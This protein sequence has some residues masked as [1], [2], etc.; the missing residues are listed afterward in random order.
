MTVLLATIVFGFGVSKITTN[1]DVADVLPRGDPNT[2]AAHNLTERFRSTFTQQVTLQLHVDEVGN[3]WAKDNAKLEYRYLQMVTGPASQGGLPVNQFPTNIRPDQLNITD[4]VYVRAMEELVRFIQDGTDF[5]RTIS[6]SN[7]YALINWTIAGG[8]GAP[9][10]SSFALPGYKTP[11]D[12]QRYA[13]VDQGVKAAVLN[14]VDAIASPSWNHAAALFMPAADNKLPTPELGKQIL[15][16][17]DLYIKAVCEGK[18]EFTVF[19]DCDEGPNAGIHNR[20]LFTVDLPIA[21]AHSSALVQEDTVRLMP[22]VG[23]FILVCLY[24]AFRNFR[25]IAVCFTTLAVGVVWSYGTMGYMNIALNTLNMTIVPLVMGVGIDYSIHMINEFVEHKSQGHSDAEAFR[26][27]G[28]RSGLALL[29]ASATTVGGLT[30][31][32]FSPSV[33][34]AQLGVISAVALTTIYLLAITFIPAALT[35]LGGSEKMG[36]Q[37]NRSKLMPALARGVSRARYLVLVV[38]IVVSGMAYLGVQNLHKEAFGDPGKNYLPSDPVRQEHEKGLAYFYEASNSD[39]KAN[40][41]TFQGPGV[42]TPEAM[43]YYRAIETNLKTKSHVIPDTLRTV[44]FF[45][46]TWLKVKGGAPGAGGSLALEQLLGRGVL[47]GPVAGAANPFPSTEEEIRDEV[48]QM[49]N[50]PMRELAAIIVNYPVVNQDKELGMTAM[51]FSVRAL[52]Y[53]EAEEVWFEVFD[54]VEDANRLFGGQPPAGISVAFVG[55]TATNYLFIAKELPWLTY[56]NITSNIILGILVFSLTRSVKITFVTLLISSLTTLWWFAVLP[57]F[58]IGL[59]ITLTLPIAFIVAIGTDYAVHFMWNIRQT[60]NAREVF[61]S[62]GKAV[63]FSFLTS[64]GAFIFFIFLQNVAVSRTMIATT[65]AFSV[66]F[67]VTMLAVPTFFKVHERGW[68]P[69]VSEDEL[70]AEPLVAPKRLK[71]ES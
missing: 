40:I 67:V 3:A 20:P 35:L 57:L 10:E 59:A 39:E 54:A 29:I 22:M 38:L 58:G 34:I 1:V 69:P 37:F 17:R 41:L 45:I 66:I 18:T 47:P 24:I 49:F 32:I 64:T 25:A 4:E 52:T 71:T 42:L 2:E 33:L 28:S 43:D 30:V 21:N 61:E 7:I 19:A 56:M 11:A 6:I 60:G 31:L 65:I 14:T 63:L 13:L 27:A 12:S 5:D 70:P 9:D 53:E 68:H 36:A 55:N 8:Q 50:S 15:A 23:A 51:T 62:T 16:Q 26:L 48:N 46:D 44:P